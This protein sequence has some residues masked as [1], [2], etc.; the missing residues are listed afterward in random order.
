MVVNFAKIPFT[1]ALADVLGNCL[2]AIAFTFLASF[3]DPNAS[4]FTT[5]SGVHRVLSATPAVVI[6]STSTTI[7]NNLTT[8][9]NYSSMDWT[10]TATTMA[11][12][13]TTAIMQKIIPTI[14]P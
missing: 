5:S 10:T 4:H 11:T 14:R 8:S 13:A 6:S 1:S 9:S 2:M 12:N 3:N 7:S